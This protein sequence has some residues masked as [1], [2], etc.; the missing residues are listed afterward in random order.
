MLLKGNHILKCNGKFL[1][2][3][4]DSDIILTYRVKGTCFP[5]KITNGRNNTAIFRFYSIPGVDNKAYIDFGDGTGEHEYPFFSSG[6]NRRLEFKNLALQTTP[7]TIQSNDWMDAPVYYYQDLPPEK[8][9]IVDDEF[10]QWRDVKIR[11][12][13]PQNIYTVQVV[14]TVCDGVLSSSI[15][16][17]R[18]LTTLSYRGLMN[19]SA[20]AQDFYDSKI[21]IL[22]LENVGPVMDNGIPLWIVNSNYLE[23]INLASSVNLSGSASLKNID[24]IDKL[25]NSLKYLNIG[26]A[27][28]NYKLPDEFNSLVNLEELELQGNTNTN[29]RLPDNI[30]GMEALKILN[31]RNTRMPFSEVERILNDM[32]SLK[33]LKMAFCSYNSDYDITEENNVLEIIHIGAQ[34]WNSGNVPTFINKLKALKQLNLYDV[35]SSTLRPQLTG[36]GDFSEAI[37]IERIDVIRANFFTTTIPVW[38]SLLTKLNYMWVG[39]SFQNSGGIDSFVNN[40][41]DFVVTNASM[42]V[43]ATPFRNMTIDAYG[44]NIS[45]QDNS[46]RPSGTYQQPSGYVQGSSNGTPASPMEKI[47]VLTN[48][49]GHTWIVKPA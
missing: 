28:I 44:T 2:V 23:Y 39:A 13:K 48:Q 49:Y 42:S 43:G 17:F 30:E 16:K 29:F 12:E 24:K 10:P 19:I 14:F 20:F 1:S 22:T 41:Y 47:W 18:N 26:N 37:N 15:S 6:T 27:Q 36:W 45:D 31:I 34:A 3:T 32:P 40:F 4:P 11:F 8:I 9:G 46:T 25:S 7:E 21:R 5:S 38:F 35:D 33:E